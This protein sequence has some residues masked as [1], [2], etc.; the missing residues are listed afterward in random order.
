MKQLKRFQ[1]CLLGGAAGDALGYEVE[2]LREREIWDRFGPGGIREYALH[3]GLARISDDTQMTLF[4]ACGLLCGTARGMDWV[5]AINDAYLDWLD[6]QRGWE[7]RGPG[8]AW[9][10]RDPR[11]H[12]LRAPG[13]TC[14]HALSQ[15]GMGTLEEPI[16]QSKGCG[17]VMRVAPIGLYL[18]GKGTAEDAALLGA[19]ASALT[20]GHDLGYLPG[21]MLARLIYR[22]TE[23]LELEEA[24]REALEG[25][26]VQFR[27]AVHLGD[28]VELMDRAMALAASDV[29]DL[30]AIHALG[31]GWVGEEA[32][33]IALFC[34][35]RHPT[36][37]DGALVAAVNHNGDSDSTG[38][39]A[40]N[41][42]GAY[43][44]LEGIPAKYRE[45]LELADLILDLAQDLLDP[46]PKA[47]YA[48]I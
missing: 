12:S 18:V 20:H 26:W 47:R 48:Q 22:L 9:I 45:N 46:E 21:A 19:Q 3:G 44:G 7:H 1:G 27:G 30:E 6:T 4:T 39:I 31:E 16:N 11:L 14:L 40:G 2:F 28:F 13:N 32:L 41:I 38:A 25:T 5:R 8:T 23:G 37:F 35:L 15:G 33:A 29:P 42:L 17:G 24:A 34:A 36:D 43:L 10:C